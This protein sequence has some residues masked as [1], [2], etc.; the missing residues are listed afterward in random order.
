MKVTTPGVRLRAEPDSNSAIII[1]S[2]STSTEIIQLD[3]PWLRVQVGNLEGYV[4]LEFLD[5]YTLTSPNNPTEEEK[6]YTLDELLPLFQDTFPYKVLAAIAKQESGFKNY[7]V[8]LDGTGHGLFGLDDN[9]MLP[10]F[11]AWSHLNVGRGANAI[12]IPIGLQ[13]QFAKHI[14]QTYSN[15]YGGPYNAARVWHRGEG[16]WQD[17]RGDN[18][19]ALIRHWEQELFN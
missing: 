4:A 1:D 10:S 8:H 2:L 6:T 7:R 16:Q 17:E 19:E 14:L 11:E 3:R 13:I 12:I 9:G 15:K 5:G 18:Y